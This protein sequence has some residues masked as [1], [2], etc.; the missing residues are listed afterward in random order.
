[1]HLPVLLSL[2]LALSS[3]VLAQD[4]TPGPSP[5]ATPTPEASPSATPEASPAAPKDDVIPLPAD[6][7]GVDTP[8][9][10]ETDVPASATEKPG[11]GEQTPDSA[12]TDPNAVIPEESG[13]TGVPPPPAA[14]PSAG[15]I[16]RKLKIRYNEVKVQAGKD[17][18]VQSLWEQA[19][20]AKTPEDER[21]AYREY[22]RL[23]FKKMKKIDKDLT[24]KCEIMERAYLT[25][26]AQTRVEPT[27]PLNPPPMPEPLGN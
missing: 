6:A 3:F 23:L 12:F 22:Y 13:A 15:E 19:Q 26:L 8:M 11:T 21:A 10:S 5:E 17:P 25:R 9:V 18:A 7:G 14:G 20:A 27:I 2:F 4:A 1:M 24:E 16:Q